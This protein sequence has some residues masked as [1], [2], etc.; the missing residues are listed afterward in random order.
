MFGYILSVLCFI[1]II[2]LAAYHRHQLDDVEHQLGLAEQTVEYLTVQNTDLY[3]LVSTLERTRDIDKRVHA[4]VVET[5][6]KLGTTVQS[7][8]KTHDMLVVE[9]DDRNREIAHILLGA[10]VDEDE[11][12]P[13]VLN[14]TTEEVVQLPNGSRLTLVKQCGICSKEGHTSDEHVQSPAPGERYLWVHADGTAC[15]TFTASRPSLSDHVPWTCW[16]HREPVYLDSEVTEDV[17][18]VELP[19]P[20]D[21]DIR[22]WGDRMSDLGVSDADITRL[23]AEAKPDDN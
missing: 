8:T 18:A 23:L 9:L 4:M 14:E 17:T 1:A 7:M 10:I 13:F 6:A 15:P 20:V 22:T 21:Q 11:P 2:V 19:V 12:V 3:G 5:N 16:R